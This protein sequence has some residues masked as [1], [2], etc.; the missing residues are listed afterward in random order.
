MKYIANVIKLLALA[1]G[2]EKAD[3]LREKLEQLMPILEQYIET[4]QVDEETIKYIIDIN[5]LTQEIS[6]L[7]ADFLK[8]ETAK[9]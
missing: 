7:I 2:N 4:E 9:Q 8:Q 5:G 6:N 1:K 3:E